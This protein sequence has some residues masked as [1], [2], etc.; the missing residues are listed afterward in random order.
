MRYVIARA[1]DYDEAMAYRIFISESLRLQ[2]EG[3]YLTK[4]YMD[5]VRPK[6]VADEDNRSADEIAESIIK[7][8]GLKVGG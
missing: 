2:G 4:S 1:K 7:G 5:I 3:K 8:M 6:K